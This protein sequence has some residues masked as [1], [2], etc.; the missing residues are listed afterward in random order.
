MNDQ[1]TRIDLDQF[2][3]MA[4]ERGWATANEMERDA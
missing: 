4:V 2:P 3:G 1:N